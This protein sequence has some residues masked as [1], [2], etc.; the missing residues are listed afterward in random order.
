VNICKE[1]GGELD[2]SEC[3]LMQVPDAVF[4]LMRN[5][6]LQACNLSSN[7]ISK[8]P[9]KLAM[10]FT[11]LTELDISNNR[12]SS[13]P[14][15][16]VNCSQLESINISAN[17]F[18]HLPPVLA[19]I[20]SLTKVQAS[21]NF[22]ADVDVEAVVSCPTL[23]HLN[24]EENPLKRDVYDELSRVTSIRVILSPRELEDWE[25]LSI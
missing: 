10:N 23:E 22:I 16:M 5:T 15:E 6:P 4:H 11:L 3:Q 24:L 14:V 18:I 25:D 19:E 8:I 13:L 17:S 2:L 1:N 7:V 20:P 21:K 9:P 12:I